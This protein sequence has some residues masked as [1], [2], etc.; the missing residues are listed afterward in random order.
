MLGQD[1]IRDETGA[2]YRVVAKDKKYK[3]KENKGGGKGRNDDKIP[4]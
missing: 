1:G 2:K 4:Q 3:E